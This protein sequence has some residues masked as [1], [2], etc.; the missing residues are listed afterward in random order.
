MGDF[1]L[2]LILNDIV[3]DP[4][5]FETWRSAWRE[6]RQYEDPGA[7]EFF[8]RYYECVEAGFNYAIN[9]FTR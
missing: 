7:I 8:D 2:L 3:V 1:A 9:K 5:R 4:T 6:A